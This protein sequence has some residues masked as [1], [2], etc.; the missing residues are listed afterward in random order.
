MSDTLRI[1]QYNVQKE[2]NGTMAPLLCS[3][4]GNMVDIITI[5]ELWK[6]S[7]HLSTYNL[8]DSS[9]HLAFAP[10]EHTWVCFFINKR[11]DPDTWEIDNHN[12]PDIATLTIRTHCSSAP[13]QLQIH[14]VYSTSPTHQS[15]M[16]IL[17]IETLASQLQAIQDDT[18]IV[19]GDFNLHHPSW[20]G[21]HYLTQHRVADHLIE[22]VEAVDLD[23]A[24]PPGTTT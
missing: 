2:K 1:L 10:I 9:F 16:D 11:I 5:Q 3:D 7:H 18:Y 6:N 17:T 8:H 21:A 12:N 23:L 22:V 13:I 4:V 24:L 15:S 14:N 19:V 20:G